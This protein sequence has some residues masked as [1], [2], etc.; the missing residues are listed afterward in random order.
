MSHHIISKA[1][2]G[3]NKG[4]EGRKKNNKEERAVDL[5]GLI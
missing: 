2:P 4:K 5:Y 3:F 1:R